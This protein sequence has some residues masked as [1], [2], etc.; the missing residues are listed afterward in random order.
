MNRSSFIL[1]AILLLAA[2]TSPAVAQTPA[3]A[4]VAARV[5]DSAVTIYTWTEGG[6]FSPGRTG[7][8]PTGAGSGWVYAAGIVVTNAHVVDGVDRVE[9]VTVDGTA[10]PA[11]IAGSDWYQDV[12]VL[13]LKP[14]DGQ[15]PPATVGASDAVRP[16]DEVIA[17]GTPRG[18][19]ANTVTTGH[20]AA[21]GVSLD[22]GADYSL[23]HLIRHDATIV[24]GNSGGPLFSMDGEVI[25]M[26]VASTDTPAGQPDAPEIAFAIE[27]DAVVPIVEEILATGAVARPYLGVQ[28]RVTEDG[29]TVVAQVAA[30]SPAAG[31]GIRPGDAIVAVDGERV[32]EGGAFIDLLYLHDPG[33]TV[34][35]TIEGEGGE[36][37]VD[38]T[39]ADGP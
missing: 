15:E 37:R 34:A 10:I 13:R 12:A 7:R 20:V 16:G 26:N 23:N 3:A 8:E 32:G 36:R 29:A 17:I 6:A 38:V 9:V 27:S 30:G 11:E 18:Q 31:A 25:G 5:R 33:D 22:T 24:P 35:L 39:L 2:P 28:A 14:K 1:V 21:T 19:F 4:D